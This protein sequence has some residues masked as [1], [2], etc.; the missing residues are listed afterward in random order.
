MEPMILPFTIDEIHDGT[1]QARL[2]ALYA[3]GWRVVAASSEQAGVS[4]VILER[5]TA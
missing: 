4:F 3:D 2:A 5:P 1:M